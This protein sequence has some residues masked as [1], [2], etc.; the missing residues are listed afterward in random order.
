MSHVETARSSRAAGLRTRRAFAFD[1]VPRPALSGRA[2]LPLLGILLLTGPASG[3]EGQTIRRSAAFLKNWDAAGAAKFQADGVTSLVPPSL[4]DAEAI[5]DFRRTVAEANQ[6]GR[7]TIGR[8]PLDYRID[9]FEAY[10]RWQ[11]VDLADH[12]ART[13]EGDPITRPNGNVFLCSNSPF[14]REAMKKMVDLCSDAG[15]DWISADLQTATHDALKLGG[16]FCPHCEAG[17]AAC[18]GKPPTWRYGEHLRSSGFDTTARIRKEARRGEAGDMPFYRRYRSY[19]HQA[20]RACYDAIRN[21]RKFLTSQDFHGH[22]APMGTHVDFDYVG[23][24]IN[25]TSNAR[26]PLLYALTD[27]AGRMNLITEGPEGDWQNT[28]LA[29][30]RQCQAY[31]WGAVWVVPHEQGIKRDGKWKRVNPPVE[32]LYAFIR[33]HRDLFDGY[34]PWP[35]VGL[36]YSHLGHRYAAAVSE[37][38]VETLVRHNVPFRLCV[39]GSDWWPKELDLA[40]LAGYV[41]T[42][43]LRYLAPADRQ[44]I[45]ALQ[46]P[47]VDVAALETLWTKMDRPI[48]V[49]LGN[50]H[51][52]VVPR[53]RG[54]DRLLHLVNMDLA[55]THRDFTVTLSPAFAG[56]VAGATL[57]APGAA[58]LALEIQPAGRFTRIRVP[59]LKEWAIVTLRGEG[60]EG[61]PE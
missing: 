60:V 41:T 36:V 22:S 54:K 46:A 8:V 40:G 7:I 31:A 2:L 56:S 28:P 15:C 19:Q 45:T 5:A 14:I 21:E 10:A 47:V 17:F 42:A 51:V 24:A 48:D 23:E 4:V 3:G 25:R 26:I 13:I 11:G 29:R 1:V 53:R 9:I 44:R 61:K 20:L 59:V 30:L 33:T 6:D 39:A 35:H 50:G 37:T 38:A 57:H 32:D 12:T 49:S 58:P 18:L 55:T 34:E 27:A 52:N 43:D 16:C